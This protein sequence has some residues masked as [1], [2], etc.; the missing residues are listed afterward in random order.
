MPY[1]FA[2]KIGYLIKS[3]E[4]ASAALLQQFDNNLLKNNPEK[5]RYFQKSSSENVKI[6]IGEHEIE[7]SDCEKLLGVFL[8]YVKGLRKN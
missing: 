4:D 5:C 2:G 1:I 3:L 6:N 8:I 7:N